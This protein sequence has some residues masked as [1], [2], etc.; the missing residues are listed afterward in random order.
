MNNLKYVSIYLLLLLVTSSFGQTINSNPDTKSFPY[1]QFTIEPAIGITPYPISDIVFSNLIQWN[2]KKRLSF[3]S[4][5]SYTHNSA[6]LREFNY[7]KTD[8][9]YSISQKFGVGTSLYSKKTM[10]SFSLIAG[11]K[12]EAFKETLDNP[13]FE[14]V[15]M[16]TSSTKP[17]FGLLYNMKKGMKKYFYSYRMYIPL[18]PYPF[19]TTDINSIDGN[20][21]NISIEFGVGILLK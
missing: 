6:F 11:V 17:D 13:E 8:Y 1:R 20:L 3:V 21:A 15:S 5:T 2:V 4:Y 19:K 18:Y 12:H 10:H 16:S 14:K 7:I 9:N